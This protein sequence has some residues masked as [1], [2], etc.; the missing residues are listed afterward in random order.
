MPHLRAALFI[1]YVILL[2]LVMGLAYSPILLLHRRYSV[3]GLRQ[4][5]R[6]VL[7]GLRVIAGVG[8]EIRGREN[9]PGGACLIAARHQSMW[10]T[11]TFN[12]V[13]KDPAFI[14]KRELIKIPVY[15]WYAA[16]LDM[17]A[18]DRAG[19]AAAL[20]AML[21][22][23]RHERESGRPIVIFPEGTRVKPGA[24]ETLKPGVAALYKDLG[25]PCIPV[26]VRSGAYWA[27]DNLA[28][29]PGTAMMQFG[30]PIPPGLSRKDFMARLEAA[31]DETEA[32]LPPAADAE[33]AAAASAP[34]TPR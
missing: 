21:R 14:L 13:L 33:P 10:E 1:A 3:A 5:C 30:T 12:L 18:I 20:K 6:L 19:H 15:G 11:V 25:L 23:A 22:A 7:G 31:L 9:L 17:I 8:Y 32:R 26:A 4:W 2:T 34:D 24:S 16:K 28:L 29:R 27:A